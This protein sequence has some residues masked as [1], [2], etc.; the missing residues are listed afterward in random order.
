[1]DEKKLEI[2]TIYPLGLDDL[3]MA[4]KDE[5]FVAKYLRGG[6]EFSDEATM[7]SVR[8]ASILVLAADFDP[9][10]TFVRFTNQGAMIRKSVL[11][12]KS[13]ARKWATIVKSCGSLDNTPEGL[14]G[15]TEDYN[16]RS[17]G[18]E[19]TTA[20]DTS[21][22]SSTTENEA[23][24]TPPGSL[25]LESP[26]ED[27]KD[28]ASKSTQ[29]GNSSANRQA[30]VDRNSQRDYSIERGGDFLDKMGKIMG[31]PEAP[32]RIVFQAW[33]PYILEVEDPAFCGLKILE[34]K[35]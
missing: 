9:E 6:D 28:S 23:A 18:T 14:L 11:V 32:Y 27:Y 8:D 21:T 7:V 16:E 19:S 17:T 4:I 31:A 2:V 34:E 22:A 5:S 15:S 25:S 12:I 33:A 1:M 26:L 3:L 30:N 10:T 24:V 35:P 20:E 29:N 13:L